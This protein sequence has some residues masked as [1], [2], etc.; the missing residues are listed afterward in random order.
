M[1][2]YMVVFKCVGV[3]LCVC[4]DHECETVTGSMCIIKCDSVCVSVSTSGDLCTS[5]C[6]STGEFVQDLLVCCGVYM[7][8]GMYTCTC[9]CVC[10]PEHVSV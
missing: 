5:R 8:V 6:V 9:V 3:C 2:V 10:S 7:R 1:N 4:C